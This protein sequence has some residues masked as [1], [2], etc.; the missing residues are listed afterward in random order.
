MIK[1][2]IHTPS[3]GLITLDDV[4]SSMTV[5]KLEST[6]LEKID[7]PSIQG[8]FLKSICQNWSSSSDDD[9]DMTI[10]NF[11]ELDERIISIKNGSSRPRRTLRVVKW[12]PI[13]VKVAPSVPDSTS[14]P[15]LDPA[16]AASQRRGSID[17]SDPS[18]VPLPSRR[19]SRESIVYQV[20]HDTV[21]MDENESSKQ[22]VRDFA[23]P[24]EMHVPVKF[25][26]GVDGS[27]IANV[28]YQTTRNLMTRKNGDKIEVLHVCDR[29][30]GWLPYDLKPDYI[31]RQYD[32]LLLDVPD[33]QRKMTILN[34]PSDDDPE[35]C[36]LNKI[37]TKALVCHYANNPT[38]PDGIDGVPT[39]EVPDVLVVG[40]VGRKGPKLDPHVLGSAVDYSMRGTSCACLVV[41]KIVSGRGDSN[42]KPRSFV[43]AVDGSKAAHQAFLDTIRLC[44]RARDMVTC[45]TFFDSRTA[46]VHARTTDPNEL[47][48][49]YS[50]MLAASNVT[51]RASVAVEKK[52]G[53]TIGAMLCSFAFDNY[54]DVLA[55]GV[56]GMKR[57]LDGG[58]VEGLGSTSDHCVKKA[59]CNVLVSKGRGVY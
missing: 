49:E 42:M 11:L 15:S 26:V 30:K 2:F 21:D 46:I 36:A 35:G 23:L 5:R 17:P 53:Q 44:D 7:D 54:C 47:A 34:K 24:E 52:I 45:V 3:S 48:E 8:C 25:L 37:G 43:V 4:D 50:K 22:T 41:K 39:H 59:K 40:M 18:H 12:I 38:Y 6:L 16:G 27:E 55:M 32:I 14:N 28:A 58:G 1:L 29:S 10:F 56:D 13:D 19:R 33:K 9:D 20:N 51:R 31:R 57:F